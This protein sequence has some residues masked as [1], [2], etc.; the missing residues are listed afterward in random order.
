VQLIIVRHGLPVRGVVDGSAADPRLSDTGRVHAEQV[1]QI[2]REERVDA[3][4]TSPLH[5]AVETAEPLAQRTG[6]TVTVDDDLA[7]YD[8]GSA[9]YIP[10]EE[11][12]AIDPA[13]WEEMRAG[14]MPSNVDSAAFQVRVTA[15]FER[16]IA[17]H[18]GRVSAAVF[19]HAGVI[20]AYLTGLLGIADPLPFAVGYGG[21]SR[22]VA[23]RGGRRA[24][25]SVNEHL[26]VRSLSGARA[27]S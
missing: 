20:N 22:V 14:L 27:N 2:L 24:V 10:V 6:L 18:P 4:Y 11:L 25:L 19:C 12:R 7:E 26:H 5:R 1:A 17:A 16:I 8:D 15:A 3:I 9:E 13:R 21:V 23:T